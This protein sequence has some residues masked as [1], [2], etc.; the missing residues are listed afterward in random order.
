MVKKEMEEQFLET[1][2]QMINREMA[3][4]QQMVRELYTRI[5]SLENQIVLLEKQSKEHGVVLQQLRD[6]KNKQVEFLKEHQLEGQ[7]IIFQEIHVDKLF[8]D[9]YEQ[10]NNLG[11]LGIKELTGQ[12]YIGTTYDKAVIPDELAEEWK[13]GIQV[14][15]EEVKHKS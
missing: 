15:E 12:L 1:I 4:F 5:S 2:Q 13:K 3:P 9:K 10:T 11:Q 8:M 6:T 14:K 7:P